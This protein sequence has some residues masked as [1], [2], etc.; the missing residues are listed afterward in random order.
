MRQAKS[1]KCSRCWPPALVV[2]LVA[3]PADVQPRSLAGEGARRTASA[4]DSLEISP[5]LNGLPRE[6]IARALAHPALADAQVG[7][8]VE[9]LASRTPLA[10]KNPD[11]LLNPASN[12]K[13]PTTA[14]VLLRLGPEYRFSTEY[15]IDGAIENGV[16]RGNLY[17]SGSGDPSIGT[18]RLLE[19]V[20]ELRLLGLRRITGGVVVDDSFFDREQEAKGWEQEESDRTY[21]APVGAL[22]INQNAVTVLVQPGP[23]V[24]APAAVTVD[25]PSDYILLD[26]RVGTAGWPGRIYMSSW[27]VEQR[28]RVRL[29]GR[30][31]VNSSP[32]RF[33]RRVTDPALHFGHALAGLMRAAGFQVGSSV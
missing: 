19:V 15:A 18:S 22:S 28:T 25:P 23:R 9:A 1:L 31:G 26:T 4:T 11:L 27:P 29:R 6:L 13:L 30:I 17:V 8:Y 2:W 24:G 7:F 5:L 12:A 21:L 33:S 10:R 20:H 14:A 16:V 3:M 32:Q